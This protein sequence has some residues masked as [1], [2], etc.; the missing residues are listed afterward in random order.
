MASPTYDMYQ[1]LSKYGQVGDAP[2]ERLDDS[3]ESL[4]QTTVHQNI[5]SDSRKL[6]RLDLF[7]RVLLL[8]PILEC[9]GVLSAH[10]DLRLLGSS[11]L[12]LPSHELLLVNW[13]MKFCHVAQSGLELLGSSNLPTL[14]S[15]KM[16]CHHV[17][18]DDL[19]PPTS[20]DSPALASQSAEI[21]GMRAGVQ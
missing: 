13:Q 16:R 20:D 9:N 7:W 17:G 1:V 2:A 19:D 5:S 15:Q 18:Q 4:L 3:D 14:A 11:A 6:L 8:M 10:R 12:T 21:T